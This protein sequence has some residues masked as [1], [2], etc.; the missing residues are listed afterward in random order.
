MSSIRN[1]PIFRLFP[2]G[3]HPLVIK[4]VVDEKFVFP[5][6]FIR[7]NRG[8]NIYIH[9]AIMVDVHHGDT[10]RPD[11]GSFYTGLCS[12]IIEFEIAPVQIKF[13]AH[14]VSGK[15]YIL[16]A[17][18]VK[19]ANAQTA[20]IVDIVKVNDVECIGGFYRV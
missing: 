12:D 10:L 20:T 6:F 18:I 2:E 4:S 17:I 13:I 8:T 7:K 9:P 19:I 16:Q 3:W 1:A 15:I 14:F 5:F 11:I